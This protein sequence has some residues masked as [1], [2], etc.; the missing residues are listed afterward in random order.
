MEKGNLVN[1]LK[2]EGDKISVGDIIAEIETDKATM[3]VE[4]MDSGILGKILVPAGSEDVLVNSKIAIL[5]ED[6]EKFDESMLNDGNSAS[7]ADASDSQ[8]TENV[9]NLK[10]ENKNSSEKPLNAS[11]NL[12]SK[13]SNDDL[14]G[15]RF[16]SPLA[17]R[18][19]K[20]NDIKLSD[21]VG[22]GP[23]GRI[24]RRDVEAFLS[25]RTSSSVN[26]QKSS[27]QNFKTLS[28]ERDN[29]GLPPYEVIKLSSMRKTIAKRLSESKQQ[30]P[31]F[32]LTV[33]I[34]IDELL[35]VRKMANTKFDLKLTVN[36][37]IIKAVASSLI[38]VP[39]ANCSYVDGSARQFSTADISV[40]VAIDGGL[41]TPIVKSA[42][43]KSIKQISAEVKDMAS[44]AKDGKLRPE[45]FTGGTFSIS[46]LGMFGIDN[47]SAIINPP[48]GCILAVG[49]GTETPVVKNGNITIATVMKCTLSVDHRVVDGAVGAKFLQSLKTMLEN[50][51][52]MLI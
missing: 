51:A 39:E 31:H 17:K 44:R 48:Q 43:M 25:D 24:I 52:M 29:E 6:G 38:E 34:E 36:D 8:K 12:E 4:S 15:R 37:F 45:E 5:L 11:N 50:P 46:N 22:T 14:M 49:K 21:L 2:K 10:S 19:A 16:I 26:S 28:F 3:E 33:N 42:E 1:W 7:N 13:N 41:I 40:A 18:I 35:K 23:N 47:F 27:N 30:V 20:L 32:Y 9:Q